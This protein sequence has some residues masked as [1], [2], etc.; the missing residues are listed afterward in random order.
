MSD[1]T[2]QAGR[3]PCEFR[4]LSDCTTPYFRLDEREQWI[5]HSKSHLK[6]NLPE[7]SSCWF[8]D[9]FQFQAIKDSESSRKQVF[10]QRMSHIWEHFVKDNLTEDSIRPDFFFLDHTWRHNLISQEKYNYCRHYQEIPVGGIYGLEYEPEE[11][12][13]ARER[14]TELPIKP[15]EQGRKDRRLASRHSTERGRSRSTRDGSK[16]VTSRLGH[17]RKYR[18]RPFVIEVTVSEPKAA[19]EDSKEPETVV[20][21]QPFVRAIRTPPSALTTSAMASM[22]KKHGGKQTKGVSFS[23]PVAATTPRSRISNYFLR[24]FDHL[25]R[26]LWPRLAHGMRCGKSLYIDAP[27]SSRQAAVEFAQEAAGSSSSIRVTESN[28]AHREHSGS[29]SQFNPPPRSNTSLTSPSEP[30]TP[31]EGQPG[32][33]FTP[34]ELAPGTKK[35]LLLC[36]NTGPYQIRL[37]QIDLTRIIDDALLYSLIREKYRQLRGTLRRNR[38][39]V[40]R[41]IEYVKFE[42][43]LRSRTGECVGNYEKDS[44]PSRDEV[45]KRE[46]TFSPCPP[47]VGT[48]PIQPHVFMHSFLNPGDHL[49]QLTVLQLPKKVGR[50]LKCVTQPR[51]PSD[52]PYGWGI[53]IVEGLDTLLVSLLL[54]VVLSSVTLLVVLWSALEG[55]VQGGT[56]LGQ[57]ALAAV[58]T[59]VAI[60]AF[61]WKPLRDV[62]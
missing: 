54:A 49:G 50:R 1:Q 46:Y 53:Y 40:P 57:Y 39:I 15:S 11:I 2:Y 7:R 30:P 32:F 51:D 33:A 21:R 22:L 17:S 44:I 41:T 38:F 9:N 56:G 55:D 16:V 60:G 35:Y 61:T 18:D 23:E 42:L 27:T 24:F 26:F 62:T 13:K 36:V 4:W 43:V 12:Q 58:G 25:R 8:C 19:E 34:P 3:L 59:A 28:H 37:A 31:V 48:V 5:E 47:R 45:T 20:P 14:K 29:S 52:V 10:E 6:D